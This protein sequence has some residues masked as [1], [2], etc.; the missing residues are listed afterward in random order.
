MT[1][2]R[3]LEFGTRVTAD[4]LRIRAVRAPAAYE[5]NGDDG[6]ERLREGCADCSQYTSHH[7]L[8]ELEFATDPLDP[9]GEEV[10]ADEDDENANKEECNIHACPS[11]DVNPR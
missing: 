7:T 2:D 4:R 11:Y 10:T 8:R 1:A 9:V 3:T 6:Y 5:K